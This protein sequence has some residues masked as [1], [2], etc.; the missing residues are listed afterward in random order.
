M[1]MLKSWNRLHVSMRPRDHLTVI[2]GILSL[3]KSNS[4]YNELCSNCS[5]STFACLNNGL[6]CPG[7]TLLGV[8]FKFTG[9]KEKLAFYYLA[10]THSPLSLEQIHLRFLFGR[11]K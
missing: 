10:L 11:R 6:K 5:C 4:K 2:P 8:N 1:A 9:R 3:K 7:C